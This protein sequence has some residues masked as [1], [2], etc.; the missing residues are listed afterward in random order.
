MH[1]KER[2]KQIRKVLGLSQKDFATKTGISY[3][4]IQNNEDIP[5]VPPFPK[6]SYQL[7]EIQYISIEQQT[8]LLSAI[9]AGDRPVF[10]FLFEYGLRVSEVCGLQKDCLSENE[11]KISRAFTRGEL[12][13]ETKGKKDRHYPLSDYAREVL[14]R[15][16]LN[17]SPYIFVRSNGKNYD[18]KSLNK[19]WHKAEAETGIKIKLQ[20]AA[21]HSLGCQ[22]ADIGVDF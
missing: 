10:E 3:R 12:R 7:P 5:K 4:S 21:R 15:A 19:I 11:V 13:E 2:I 14:G 17:F 22:L 9:P 16:R 1:S 18:T 20:N 6:L 8:A